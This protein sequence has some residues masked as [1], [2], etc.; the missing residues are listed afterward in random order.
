MFYADKERKNGCLILLTFTF[1]NLR[2][3]LST[4]LNV[5]LKAWDTNDQ[6]AKP[7]K[8]YAET[9][10]QLREINSFLLDTYDGLFPKGSNSS[11]EEIKKKSLE[12]REAYQVFMGRK[13]ISL[14][15]HKLTLIEY[16]PIFQD[17]YK[18]KVSA[19]HIQ[20]FNGIKTH[21]ET[22]Q[23]KTGTIVDFDTINKD[24]YISFTD[25]LKAA[26]LKP[27]TI[28]SHIRR[29]KRLMNEANEDKLTSNQE[30]RARN[31]KVLK[32]DADTIYLNTEEIQ[33]L[34]KLKIDD[35]RMRRI[36][37]LFILNCHTGLRHSDWS[38]VTLNN[39]EDGKLFVKTQKTKEPVII[40]VHPIILE[41]INKYG[42]EYRIPTNQEANRVL[43]WVGEYAVTKKITNGNLDKW[44]QIRT[45]TVRRSFA[46]NAYLS[47][48]PMLSIMQITGH[49]TTE[50]FLRYIRISKLE[51]AMKLKDHPFFNA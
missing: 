24:F 26:N 6:K 44:L 13:E 7:Q 38:K 14:E 21:L 47:G 41:I 29:I 34:Y 23:K 4:G 12:I 19:N 33:A 46:T 37:D 51:N 16:I 48:V 30:H 10:K 9:N 40:P 49:K 50:S 15:N 8:D 39:I 32:E 31:F 17:R 1:N 25:Y 27:N 22:F 11:K 28:G 18:N 3:R 5:P 42:A 35:E 20:H 45:H 36:R 2:L 43:R